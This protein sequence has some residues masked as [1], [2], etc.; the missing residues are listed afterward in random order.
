[1]VI[2]QRVASVLKDLDKHVVREALPRRYYSVRSDYIN[3][4]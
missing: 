3:T 1:M 2:I 4:L